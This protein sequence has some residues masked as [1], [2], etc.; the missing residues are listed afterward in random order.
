MENKIIYEKD[1][2]TRINLKTDTGHR[3]KLIDFCLN[4][5]INF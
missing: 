1:Y 4:G 2:V 3:E 5:K